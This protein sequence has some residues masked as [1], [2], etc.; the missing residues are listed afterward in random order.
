M[1][2]PLESAVH[3]D[4]LTTAFHSM[5]AHY[6]S[7]RLHY[8]IMVMLSATDKGNSTG[9]EIAVPLPPPPPNGG[10][11]GWTISIVSFG[12]QFV[13]NCA[14]GFP[15]KDCH[16]FATFPNGGCRSLVVVINPIYA[17]WDFVGL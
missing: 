12:F 7:L 15:I 5:A 13:V 4:S 2:E 17:V 11:I 6:A 3:F 1:V 9:V 16:P 8:P 10:N 14:I